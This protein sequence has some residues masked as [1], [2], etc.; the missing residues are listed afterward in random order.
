LDCLVTI[1][2]E[3]C[4]SLTNTTC[5]CTSAELNAALT[6]CVLAAC[7]VTD[8]LQLERYSAQDC[9]VPDDRTRLDEEWHGVYCVPALATVFVAGRLYARS[10]FETGL[11][12]D[13]WMIVAALASYLT[14]ICL[15]LQLLFS[16]FGRHTYWLTEDQIITALKVSALPPRTARAPTHSGKYFYIAE[17][18]YLLTITLIKLSL[19]LFFRRIFPNRI[20]RIAIWIVFG[21]VIASNFSFAMAAMLQCVSSPRWHSLC[22]Y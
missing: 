19:L 7:N 10:R 20:F 9:G 15:G 18:F 12:A 13:D 4:G 8:A 3:Y 21:F 1:V 11:G 14:D 5:T 6:P 2:P 22:Q 17:L 16:G